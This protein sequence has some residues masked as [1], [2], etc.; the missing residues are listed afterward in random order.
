MS[1][2]AGI[3]DLS[4]LVA[5]PTEHLT[6]AADHWESV[7]GRS[8]AVANQVWCDAVSVDWHGEGAEALRTASHADM[9][10]T[11]AA[12]DQLQAAAKVAHSGAAGLYAAR[13]RLRYAIEDANA[14]GFDVREDMSVTDRSGGGSAAQRAARQAQAQA[15]AA[16]IRQR[17]AQLVALDQQVA[18]KVTAAV[19]GVRDTFAHDPG[20]S[21]GS[22]N[23]S[24]RQPHLQTR[25]TAAGS[26]G[27]SVRGLD[28]R[29]ESPSGNRNRE[30]PCLRPFSGNGSA[31]PGKVY[32]RRDQGPE[33][34]SRHQQQVRRPNA[35]EG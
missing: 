26:A 18:A 33:H 17:A 7:A 6:A 5:W 2:V 22:Q 28:R 24:R 21:R 23:P 27:Q 9:L 34:S 4:G 3:P 31:R 16:D 29:A 30:R 1:G 11:S 10:T 8:Y 14:D 12:A 13:S 25:P 32:L 15:F 19:A 20:A 35:A